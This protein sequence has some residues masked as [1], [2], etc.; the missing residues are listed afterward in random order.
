MIRLTTRYRTMSC[1]ALS[2]LALAA[3]A[4]CAVSPESGGPLSREE[5]VKQAN[6]IC[7]KGNADIMAA[8]PQGEWPPS[9]EAGEAFFESVL[10]LVEQQIDDI[11]ALQPPADIQPVIDGVVVDARTILTEVEADG[12]EAFFA[13]DEDPWAAV[14]DRFKSLG[15]NECAEE[16]AE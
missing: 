16:P 15:I 5:F 14:N 2:A 4:G 7:A 1:A 12:S 11:D 6:A 9:D 10:T 8:A 3:V 13:S